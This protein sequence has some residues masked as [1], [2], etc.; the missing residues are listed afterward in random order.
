M[1]KLHENGNTKVRPNVV[2]ANA[3]INACAFTQGDVRVQNRALEIAQIVLK[4]LEEAQYGEPDQ[5]TYGTF[6]KV[7][8]NQMPASNSRDQ[9][10]EVLFKKCTQDGQLG[11][12]FLQQMKVTASR[13]LFESIIGKR[14]DESVR[15]DDLPSQ[16]S[17]NVVDKRPPRS[18]R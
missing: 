8:Q 4:D 1:K 17:A 18:R 10:V 15:L 6:L 13:E 9:V 11:D 16:W 2:A 14:A 12:Y 7:C 3:V 5:I